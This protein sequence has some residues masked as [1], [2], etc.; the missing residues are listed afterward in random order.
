MIA[1]LLPS[2]AAAV[3]GLAC[4]GS[5]GRSLSAGVAWGPL[6]LAAFAV[7][8]VLYNPPVNRLDWAI[9]AGPSIWVLSKVVMLAVFFRNAL[10]D[11]YIRPAWLV[12]CFCGPLNT[13]AIVGN[14]GP[15]PQAPQPPAAG[16]GAHD[17][18]PRAP[19]HRV[20]N[21]PP[22]SP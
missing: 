16:S 5:L 15:N 14:G 2:A 17:P 3:F 1:L 18:P 8:L 11:Q 10:V 7:E 13:I 6:L 12:I 20:G 9:G 22:L 21:A 19:P 4:G